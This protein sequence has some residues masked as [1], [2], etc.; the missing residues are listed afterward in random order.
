MSLRLGDHTA[1]RWENATYPMY[2][3]R[4]T[5]YMSTGLSILPTITCFI[6]DT[7]GQIQILQRYIGRVR[8]RT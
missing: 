5:D 7:L 2:G 8:S 4:N 3:N 6:E 1:E